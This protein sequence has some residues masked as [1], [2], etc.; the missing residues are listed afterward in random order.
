[1][2]LKS[3]VYLSLLVLVTSVTGC[4]EGPKYTTVEFTDV[5]WYTDKLPE[6]WISTA[7]AKHVNH[8]AWTTTTYYK[9]GKYMMCPITHR[10]HNDVYIFTAKNASYMQ[11]TLQDRK[12][13]YGEFDAKV[14]GRAGYDD[15]WWIFKGRGY[16]K[17]VYG[18]DEYA[19]QK[20]I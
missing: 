11:W 15:G 3:L 20:S 9:C 8:D 19:R 10:H 16:W 7:K 17:N 14:W 1:M 12:S 5:I 6:Y 4:L 18:V 2:G 13:V